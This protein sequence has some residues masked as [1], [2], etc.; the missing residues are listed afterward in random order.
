MAKPEEDPDIVVTDRAIFVL[1]RKGETLEEWLA[2][3]RKAAPPL[4]ERQKEVI[5]A[6]G[7]EYWAIVRE[8]A[9]KRKDS[10]GS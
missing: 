1:R 6:A 5:R 2:R 4:S 8:R 9:R 10:D 7:A 3:F